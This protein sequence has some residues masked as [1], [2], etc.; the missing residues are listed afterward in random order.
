MRDGRGANVGPDLT[1]I[2][3]MATDRRRL[4][5]SILHPSREI[6]PMYTTWKVLT[7][8][9]QVIVGLKLNG[10]GVGQSARYLLADSTTVDVRMED[11]EV[12]A[13]SENSIMPS[14]L[15]QKMTMEELRDLLAF[16]A[17]A[18]ES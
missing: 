8:D 18:P 7:K 16:L 14:G 13:P 12:Q 3:T 4:L 10:G 2:R 5:E 6:G 15:V 1:D 11:I 17:S 9:D